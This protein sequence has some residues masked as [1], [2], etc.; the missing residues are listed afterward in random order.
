MKTKRI[1]CML[2]CMCMF[3]SLFAGI[4]VTASADDT[5]T[6]TVQS[7]ETLAK[8]CTKYGLTFD[9]CKKAI[10]LLNPS[11]TNINKISIGQVITLPASNALAQSITQT[12]TTTTTTTTT[13][14]STSTSTSSSNTASVSGLAN[15]DSVAFYL[16]PHTMESGETLASVCNKLNSSYSTY[17]D[18]IKEINDIK[19][20]NKIWVG[21]V[22][23]IPTTTAPSS[24]SYLTVIAHAVSSG[25]TMTTICKENGITYESYYNMLVG[26]NKGVTLSRIKVGQTVYIP[27]TKSANGSSSGS[28]TVSPAGSGYK[29]TF[30]STSYGKPT[31]TFE[32]TAVTTS[33]AGKKI[34]INPNAVSGYAQSSVSVTYANS[35]AELAVYDNTFTM[36]NAD[37]FV[38]VEYK[39]GKAIYKEAT[40]GGSFETRVDG[41]D[42]GS[43]I[44]GKTVTIV[45][46]AK[47]GYSVGSVVV[48]YGSGT[49]KKAF[50]VAK[51]NGAYTFT[52]PDSAVTVAVDFEHANMWALHID[53]TVSNGSVKLTYDGYEVIKASKGMMVNVAATP[54][55]GYKVNS[56]SVS[57]KDTAGNLNPIDV[58]MEANGSS[59]FFEMPDRPVYINVIFG[60][61]TQYD[62]ST[63]Y[64]L[65]GSASSAAQVGSVSYLVNGVASSKA[66]AGDK[67]SIVVSA[68]AGYAQNVNNT[69]VTVNAGTSTVKTLVQA[70][71][72]FIM[73]NGAATV[74]VDFATGAYRLIKGTVAN[75]SVV[76][77]VNGFESST[78]LQDAKVRIYP[79]ANNGYIFNTDDKTF[80]ITYKDGNTTKKLTLTSGITEVKDSKSTVLYYEFAMPK[81][82]ITLFAGFELGKNYDLAVDSFYD[83]DGTALAKDYTNVFFAVDGVN[84]DNTVYGKTVNINVESS[85][86]YTVSKILVDG[87][88]IKANSGAY[89]FVMPN[90]AP[91]IKVYLKLIEYNVFFNSPDGGTVTISSITQDTETGLYKEG[92]NETVMFN[93]VNSTG[94]IL[95]KVT[96]TTAS[97][98]E[99]AVNQTSLTNSGSIYTYCYDFKMLGEDAVINA[100][101]S[102]TPYTI[103]KNSAT[104]GTYTLTVGDNANAVS[105]TEGSIVKV[106]ATPASGYKVASVKYDSTVVKVASDGSYSFVM[107]GKDVSIDVTFEVAKYKVTIASLDVQLGTATVEST[108][109]TTAAASIDAKYN[110]QVTVKIVPTGDYEVEKVMA[111]NVTATGSSN[112]YTFSMPNADVNV[113]IYFKNVV[114]AISVANSTHAKIVNCPETAKVGTTVNFK[115]EGISDAGATVQ[116]VSVIDGS[117]NTI[118]CTYDVDTKTGSF[119]MPNDT[120]TITPDETSKPVLY[121]IKTTVSGSGTVGATETVGGEE[122]VQEAVESATPVTVSVKPS[123]EYRLK[124]IKLYKYDGTEIDKTTVSWTEVTANS[125]YTFNMPANG[126]N[127]KAEFVGEKSYQ[128]TFTTTDA[129][130]VKFAPTIWVAGSQVSTGVDNTFNFDS[131]RYFEVSY[132]VKSGLAINKAPYYTDSSSNKVE[133]V[134]KKSSNGNYVYGFTMPAYDIT[135]TPPTTQ[136]NA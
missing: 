29:I 24:G 73:P 80:Y 111:N 99:I 91:Q 133:G 123:S 52:M 82:D 94:Y 108:S 39:A 72:T 96:V 58:E 114:K 88:E 37:V 109:V 110:E 2:L 75:G 3:A 57:V 93:V 121:A 49:S 11:I 8:I 87:E 102:K 74:S 60:G 12:T 103:T 59:G 38:T 84:V 27:T 55:N 129:N 36:P 70:E 15:G 67:V 113:V 104:N 132:D 85:S 25:D 41:V 115:V 43:A 126:V 136:S 64:L 17:K 97:G 120:V 44:F 118:T 122:V 62:I 13:I 1:L 22:I 112:T 20:L 21:K 18:M 16:V 125:K 79:T 50:T 4:T 81:S 127:I 48:S 46:T 83:S 31:A 34:T 105:A 68:K 69:K 130:G 61:N 40:I 92:Y 28:G 117:S 7:G 32:S 77:K 33:D 89:S 119:V 71:N 23:Y 98:K 116:A 128:V 86:G 78:A 107:P 106:V 65:N 124:S 9:V 45:P 134:L 19:N 26:L 51:N 54:E 101:F 6:H 56:I 10:L 131:G 35:T 53:D 42:T 14:G 90:K 100:E 95:K 63:T 76:M 66:C 5:I 30:A 47:S 135:I